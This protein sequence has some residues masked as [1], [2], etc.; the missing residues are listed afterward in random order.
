VDVN[1]GDLLWPARLGS[2]YSASP[3]Y[4]KNRIYFCSHEGKTTVVKPNAKKFEQPA[5]DEL[6]GQLTASPVPAGGAL[7]I[8]SDKHLYRIEQK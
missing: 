6:D 2:N 1:S 5:E 7:F 4:T 8:R 3:I